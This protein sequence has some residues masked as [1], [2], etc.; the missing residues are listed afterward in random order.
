MRR[1]IASE[2]EPHRQPVVELGGE[3]GL[4]A[5]GPR[6]DIAAGVGEIVG[7]ERHRDVVANLLGE[8]QIGREVGAVA[9]RV[10]APR[11]GRAEDE[12][13]K[14]GVGGLGVGE[15]VAPPLEVEVVNRADGRIAPSVVD[16][17]TRGALLLGDVV[18]VLA[19]EVLGEVLRTAHQRRL[20]AQR[21]HQPDGGDVGGRRQVQVEA[22][23][24]A[25]VPGR[26]GR[27]ART[28]IEA[29]VGVELPAR[30]DRGVVGRLEVVDIAR[31]DVG[32]VEAQLR[33]QG[34]DLREVDHQF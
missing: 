6:G 23:G 22:V 16:G 12:A 8:A 17:A 15:G 31:M 33:A 34:V 24:L 32:A 9:V 2:F 3:D 30:G 27:A 28:G 20:E 19:A 21:N 25:A 4:H 29:H 10:V 7:V 1:I 14:G 11:V 5:C 18:G 13:G 26:H